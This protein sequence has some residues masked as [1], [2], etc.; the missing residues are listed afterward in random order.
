MGRRF[1]AAMAAT[2]A[3]AIT[4][5]ACGS[6]PHITAPPSSCTPASSAMQCVLAKIAPPIR[7]GVTPTEIRGVDFG[8]NSISPAAARSLHVT[9][10]ASYLSND[11]SK[12]FSAATVKAFHADG[13]ATVDVWEA[14]ATRATEG[15]DAG[16]AD[17]RLAKEQAAALGNTSRPIV[18]AIDCDCTDASIL[19]YFQGLDSVLA[20]RVDAY[21]GYAQ[22]AFLHSQGVVGDENWQTYA[23]S[24]GQWLPATIAPLEQYLNG[25][26]YDWDRA[27]STPYGEFPW[28]APKPPV[29]THTTTTP[30][31]PPPPPSGSHAVCWGSRASPATKVCKTV[32][33]RHAWL[34]GRRDFWQHEFNRCIRY[35]D[36]IGCS[37]AERWWLL[38]RS[39]ALSLYRR[40]TV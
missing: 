2:L 1:L 39:Q 8:W 3:A 4:V 6:S 23:W 21:G 26:S 14:T 11:P 36:G 32:L 30:A 15:R 9:F 7:Y 35:A 34:I 13:I 40:Y 24:D 20:S 25:T 31:P 19:A 17:A 28:T 12:D 37:R 22:V 5:A 29:V 18:F 16:I 10:V 27:I 33:K 38:R